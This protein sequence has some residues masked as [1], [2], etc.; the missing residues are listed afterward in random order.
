MD[1]QI[2]IPLIITLPLIVFWLWMFRDMI[3]HDNL[4]GSPKDYWMLAFIFMNV[5]AAVFYY[6]YEYRK[7]HQPLV[8]CLEG[9]IA[10]SSSVCGK[11]TLRY[12]C[13]DLLSS[14]HHISF[15]NPNHLAQLFRKLL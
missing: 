15:L 6:V 4:P 11:I 13:D 10:F 9:I 8:T 2:V 5:F 14:I 3:N 1:R 12:L 7:R